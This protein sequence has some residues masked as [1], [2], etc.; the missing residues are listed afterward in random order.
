MFVVNV[1]LPLTKCRLRLSS[2][3][4]VVVEVYIEYPDLMVKT[5]VNYLIDTSV[6]YLWMQ[7]CT[8]RWCARTHTHTCLQCM[9]PLL[10]YVNIRIRYIHICMYVCSY[11]IY[12]I[13][14][15]LYAMCLVIRMLMIG[16]IQDERRWW[17][18]MGGRVYVLLY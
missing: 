9:Y 13:C 18:W 1:C 11:V 16:S 8:C 4:V 7:V 5:N 17:R 12:T 15:T 2:G 3:V 14:Y 6:I 10:M